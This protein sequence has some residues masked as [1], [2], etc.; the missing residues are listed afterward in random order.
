LHTIFE[1]QARETPTAIA[2]EVPPRRG[3]PRRV[4]VTYAELDERA[5]ALARRLAPRVRSECVVAIVLPRAG[6]ELPLA[7]LAVLK[8][9][10][11]WTCI[12]PDTPRERLAY[13]L[14]DSRAVAVIAGPEQRAALLDAGCDASR[15]VDPAEPVRA[16]P[17]RGPEPGWLGPETLAYV[18]Y[19]SGTTGPTSCSPT[20]PASG[21]APPTAAPRPRRPPT[22][23][24]SRRCGS[25]GARGRRS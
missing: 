13:L 9:G 14:E 16:G 15:I 3:D 7:Q 8:A 4:R 5:G 10:A 12:E 1:E 11:A 2:L 25:P 22:T 24:R 23:P 21:S 17:A 18:I 6:V 20:R 19:T